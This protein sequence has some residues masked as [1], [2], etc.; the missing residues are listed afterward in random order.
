MSSP[1]ASLLL[2]LL[3]IATKWNTINLLNTNN[4]T[5][6]N[7]FIFTNL[8]KAALQKPQPWQAPTP[9]QPENSKPTEPSSI[10]QIIKAAAGRFGIDAELIR[11]VVHTES[12][13]KPDAKSPAGA[14]G[15]MQLMPGTAAAYGVTDLFNPLQNVMGG[16]HYLKDMLERYNGNLPLALAAYNAGPGT[17]DRYQGIPPYRE[18]RSYVNK[19]MA[20]LNRVDEK[21]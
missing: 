5:A 11:E 18:T 9:A 1:D 16:T 19:I 4:A 17:V 14:K 2:L 8:L 20:N 6:D 12:A 7:E 21:V 15:L 13:F 10:D 3:D